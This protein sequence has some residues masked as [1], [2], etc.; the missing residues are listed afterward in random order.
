MMTLTVLLI[1]A[2]ARV[3]V[4]QLASLPSCAQDCA[5]HYLTNSGDC[6]SDPKCICSNK[7]FLSNIACCVAAVCDQSDQASAI[8]VAVDVGYISARNPPR[9]QSIE[10]SNHRLSCFL[11][12]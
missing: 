2:L 9:S 1:F 6:G 8:S 4:G 10:V 5:D 12:L 11:T 7:D 3:A